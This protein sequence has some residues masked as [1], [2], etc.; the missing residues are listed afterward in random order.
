MNKY[1]QDTIGKVILIRNIVF[2][3]PD[4]KS[5]NLD[6]VWKKGRPCIIIYS[7]DEYDYFLPI[8]SNIKEKF[9]HQYFMLSEKDLLNKDIH[10]YSKSRTNYNHSLTGSINLETIYKIPISGHDEVSKVSWETFKNIIEKL[11]EYHQSNNLEEIINRAEIMRGA[12]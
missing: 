12:R 6:H 3:N 11:K 9:D 4:T 2:F 8:K 1:E 10:R 5:K 7:D